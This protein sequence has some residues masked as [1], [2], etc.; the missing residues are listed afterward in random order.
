MFPL[1][2][3]EDKLTGQY[4]SRA[5]Y[6]AWHKLL[7]LFEFLHPLLFSTANPR[8]LGL[9]HLAQLDS[10]TSAGTHGP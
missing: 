8:R 10:Q 4:P 3:A 7:G 2:P 5:R 9:R 6:H 1:L